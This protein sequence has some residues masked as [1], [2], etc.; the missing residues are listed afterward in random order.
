VAKGD[1]FHGTLI[2]DMDKRDSTTPRD[3]T[4]I[5]AGTPMKKKRP[6]IFPPKEKEKKGLE[7]IQ[8]RKNPS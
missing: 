3:R 4:T 5:T 1:N 6:D 7:K 8:A 2:E